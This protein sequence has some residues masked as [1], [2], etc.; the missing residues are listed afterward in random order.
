[1][2]PISKPS[3]NAQEKKA[4]C[5]V[6]KSGM[7]AQGPR[8]AELENMF[9]EMNNC[10][11][12]V[13]V[14]SGT[15]ALHTALWAAGIRE[16]DEVITTPFTF[17]ATANAI[18]MCGAKPVFVD[19]E[20][21]TF[22]IDPDE[23]RNKLT[24]KTKAILPVSLYGLPYDFEQISLFAHVHNL[25]V[26][27]DAC[28]AHGAKYLNKHIGELGDASCFSFYATKNAMC[29]EGGIITTNC[30]DIYNKAKMF[31]HHGQSAQY[32]YVE[33][34]YN[35]RLTDLQAAIAIEQ[36]HK[37]YYFDQRRQ[38]NAAK[39]NE[40]FKDIKSIKIPYCPSEIK[41]AYHQY[42]LT[43]NSTSTTDEQLR[44]YIQER[45]K[46]D[47]IGCGVYYPKPLHLHP[48]FSKYGYK[49]GDFPVAESLSKR[50]LSIPV[51]PGIT[52]KDRKKIITAIVDTC[53]GA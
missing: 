37:L 41:H 39:Y 35:Y 46:L 11:Y 47:G 16:G 31:R 15:A 44:T 52:Q 32:E 5:S 22:N 8:V 43:M 27:H 7:L 38:E 18:I 4:I 45:F 49:Q 9:K 24:D 6:L 29:G 17:V 23:I 40:V 30:E 42:T 19:V 3:I 48:N 34:G 20:N 21:D 13:A 33:L 50:V 25:K 26:I 1:M 10:Q 51:H 53:Y 12:A 2:I 36:L 14:S 28:Q